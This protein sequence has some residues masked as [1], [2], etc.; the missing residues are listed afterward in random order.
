[1]PDTI[2]FVFIFLPLFPSFFFL[3]AALYVMSKYIERLLETIS[4]SCVLLFYFL[5]FC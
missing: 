1:M 3:Y 5:L 4:L 2:S